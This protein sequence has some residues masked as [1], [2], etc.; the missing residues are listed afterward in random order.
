MAF[1]YVY[2]LTNQDS[3]HCYVGITKDLK[4]RLN[5]HNRGEVAHTAKNRPWK[6][7]SATAFESPEKASAFEKY[8]KTH[9]GR[10]WA[11]RHL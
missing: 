5:R 4:D 9:A 7:Q 10:E 2:T 8:L 1:T 11:K 6:I 3:T